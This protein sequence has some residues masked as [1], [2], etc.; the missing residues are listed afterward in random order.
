M[1]NQNVP[2]HDSNERYNY[3]HQI[4]S[5]SPSIT[6]KTASLVAS[7]M[8]ALGFILPWVNIPNLGFLRDSLGTVNGFKIIS[9]LSKKLDVASFLGILILL[10][11]PT[12]SII[13]FITRLNQGYENKKIGTIAVSILSYIPILTLLIYLNLGNQLGENTITQAMKI[14]GGLGIGA[15]FM[16]L[17]SVFLVVDT[18]LLLSKIKTSKQTVQLAWAKGAMLGGC[19]GLSYLLIAEIVKNSRILNGFGILGIPMLF[20]IFIAGIVI[21]I[22]LHKN[23]DLRR[24]ITYERALGTGVITAGMAGIATY[25]VIILDIPFLESQS[26]GMAFLGLTFIFTQWGFIVSSI[27][28]YNIANI[29]HKAHNNHFTHNPTPPIE[30]SVMEYS[31]TPDMNLQPQYVTT[32]VREPSISLTER[33]LPL[34]DWLRKHVVKISILAALLAAATAVYVLF[35]KINPEREAK[36]AAKEKCDCWDKDRTQLIA[37]LDI[38]LNG[39]NNG[40]YKRKSEVR[41]EIDKYNKIS[42]AYVK[43]EETTS[44]EARNKMTNDLDKISRFNIAYSA[45]KCDA[46][47]DQIVNT[48]LNEIEQKIALIKDPEPDA[49]K[50]KTDLIGTQLPGFAIELL[51][52]IK[53]FKVSNI[54]KTSDR[55]EY[56]VD[57]KLIA[58]NSNFDNDCQVVVIYTQNENGWNFNN[59]KTQFITFTNTFY[60]DRL[61]TI[62]PLNNCNW[63]SENHYKLGWKTHNWEYAPEVTTGP[64]LGQKSLPSSD[65]Y[66][67]RSLEN[68]SVDVKFTYKPNY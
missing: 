15:I 53:D 43:C 58:K 27:A 34:L 67:I 2:Y 10:C 59:V 41:T 8:V 6:M 66:Y 7:M 1:E 35:I 9:E 36:N 44:T 61:T 11:I 29:E 52:D 46:S 16:I 30:S 31:Q 5:Q 22:N 24:Q 20:G 42:D 39:L 62:T 65:V 60:T 21:A 18:I 40:N 12:F 56:Q 51:S 57:M 55:I 37:N 49:D 63:T 13:F 68:K 25:I 45:Y 48:K 64:E 54:T 17:G 14:G 38:I 47:K 3:G 50:L 32:I 4:A 28:A 26:T 23:K 33:L 19:I